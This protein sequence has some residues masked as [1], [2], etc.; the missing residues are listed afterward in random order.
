V[1]VEVSGVFQTSQRKVAGRFEVLGVAN[2]SSLVVFDPAAGTVYT[3]GTDKESNIYPRSI[4][5]GKGGRIKIETQR[6]ELK[7]ELLGSLLKRIPPGGETFLNGAAKTADKVLIRQNPEEYETVKKGLDELELRYATRKDLLDPQ[8]QS[9]FVVT[10]LVFIQTFLPADS[11]SP[12]TPA[13]TA[14]EESE[15]FNDVTDLFIPDVRNPEKE[16]L[17]K[18]G[19]LIR[20]AQIIA[21]LSE[22]DEE[23]MKLQKLEESL[24]EA[25]DLLA[26]GAVSDPFL[27]KE[28]LA[29]G[30]ARQGSLIYSPVDGKILSLRVHVIN[31][32]AATVALR[33]LYRRE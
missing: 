5:A 16:I 26:I 1:T 4:L 15:D 31:G 29:L 11:P 27:Q 28:R 9:L 8:V 10:G 21:R 7:N 17:V 22:S 32:N 18:E 13:S 20:K 25:E 12:E 23:G 3:V 2:P 14:P 33:V 6:V 19:D 30:K 24:R